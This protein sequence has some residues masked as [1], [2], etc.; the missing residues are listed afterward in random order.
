[1]QPR[2]HV[3]T[4]AVRDL[5]VALTFTVTASDWSHEESSAR[6]SKVT[7]RNRPVPSRCSSSTAG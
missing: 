2:I 6:S 7:T 3:I 1:V 4:L 5:E